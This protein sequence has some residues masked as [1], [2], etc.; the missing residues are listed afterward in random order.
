MAHLTNLCE[1]IADTVY[2]MREQST[3]PIINANELRQLVVDTQELL[4]GAKMDLLTSHASTRAIS[5]SK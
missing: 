3:A 2:E 5:L 1:S 4:K